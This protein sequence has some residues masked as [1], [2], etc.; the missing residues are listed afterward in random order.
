MADI[1]PS[2]SSK[3]EDKRGFLARFWGFDR[4]IGSALIKAFYYIGLVLITIQLLPIEALDQ[5]DLIALRLF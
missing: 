2:R 4:L 5:I 3:H 1:S